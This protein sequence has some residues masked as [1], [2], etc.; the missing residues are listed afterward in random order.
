MN[1]RVLFSLKDKGIKKTTIKKNSVVC[2]N[3]A[4]K[5][6]QQ[7]LTLS[8]KSSFPVPVSGDKHFHFLGVTCLNLKG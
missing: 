5:G 3:F 8:C 2:L 7:E 1:H 4:W 6:S